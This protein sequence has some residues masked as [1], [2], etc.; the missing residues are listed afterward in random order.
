MTTMHTPGP[1]FVKYEENG[2]F[3]VMDGP[4]PSTANTLCTRFA[5]KERE[6]EM[7]ANGNL[8]AAAPDLLAALNTLSVAVDNLDPQSGVP[9]GYQALLD[10]AAIAEFAIAKA[11][12]AAS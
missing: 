4:N 8:F 9:I 1:F 10:A 3:E 6:A 5:W 7:R 2:Y 11:T 12:G